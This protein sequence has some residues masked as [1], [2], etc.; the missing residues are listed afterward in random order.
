[1]VRAFS[2]S[3][4]CDA[5]LIVVSFMAGGLIVVLYRLAS[6]VVGSLLKDR[7]E[8]LSQECFHSDSLLATS[9]KVSN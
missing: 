3:Y 6:F 7:L 5:G 4:I 2:I 1:M 8:W 9:P